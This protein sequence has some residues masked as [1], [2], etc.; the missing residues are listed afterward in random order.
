ME[1]KRFGNTVVARLDVKDEI[2]TSVRQICE[3]EKIHTASVQAIGA[4]NDFT[5]GLYNT[6]TKK[7]QSTHFEFPA[8]ITA[9]LGNITKKD[10][11]T[12]IHLH[13]TVA[14][15][16]GHAFGGHLNQAIISATCEIFIQ[17]IDGEV[18]RK[19]DDLT[20]LNV[21]QF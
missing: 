21:F 11:Q 5:I 16:E 3:E 4:T 1:Y 14:D 7:Y 15:E 18:T 2:I 20:G 6:D 17:I 9:L 19:V 13:L 12:Y 10:G 8:E